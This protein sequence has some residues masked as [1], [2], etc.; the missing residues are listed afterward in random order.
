ML[1]VKNTHDENPIKARH[2]GFLFNTYVLMQLFNLINARKLMP[3]EWNPFANFFNN[4]YF[5]GILIVAI[6]VQIGLVEIDGV[7]AVL[8]IQPQTMTLLGISLGIGASGI[9]WGNYSRDNLFRLRASSHSSVSV[10]RSET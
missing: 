1:D 3:H 9:I 5:L 7:S 4:R 8:K 6:V 2:Y 10:R